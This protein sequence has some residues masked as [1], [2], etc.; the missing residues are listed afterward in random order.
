MN[1][2]WKW[3]E[4]LVKQRKVLQEGVGSKKDPF[5]YW[6]PGMEDQWQ[7]DFLQSLLKPMEE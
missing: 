6:L 1:T 2:L 7:Q 3:L 4:R 5:V